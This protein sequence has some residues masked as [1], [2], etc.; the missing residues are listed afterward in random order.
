[1]AN[2]RAGL[3]GLGMMGRH[4]ARV[5]GSL[6]GVDL[7]AVADPGGDVHTV[8]GGRPVEADIDSLIKHGLDYCMVA[9]PTIYHERI[10]LA[11]ADAGVHALIEKPLAQDTPSSTRVAE[12]FESHD[13]VGAVGHIE[14]YNPALQQARARIEAGDLGEVYQ[15]ITR[16]QGPFPA[17]IADVGVVKDL[18][19]HDIDLTAWVTQ[20]EFT[21]VAARTAHRSGR[22]H[23]DMVAVV[24]QLSSGTITSHLV[25]WL[26]PFKERVTIITG[27][28]GCF[29]ADTL[30]ADLTFHANGE[31]A[32]AWEGISKFRGV[33]EGDMVRYAIHKPEPLRTEHEQFRDAVLGKDADIVTM[34]Q[35]LT[36]VRVA[37]ACLESALTST[38]VLLA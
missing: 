10:G 34:R 13:L 24:G 11:L 26:S 31:I 9:V 22:E 37:E 23:E 36:T 16:R 3:I 30:T 18:G 12:A 14:R 35:G 2:L 4:H 1:M 21:S 38:T 5:L 15:V 17:R 7:V 29:I 20:Q 25:N 33:S 28:R 6:D 27:S 32:Q 8:A 19:T